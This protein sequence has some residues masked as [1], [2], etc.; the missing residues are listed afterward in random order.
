MVRDCYK[1]GCQNAG[2]QTLQ[3]LFICFLMMK[4][5]EKYG[6]ILQ[7][8]VQNLKNKNNF[9]VFCSDHFADEDFNCAPYSRMPRL[10]SHAMPR[11][12]NESEKWMHTLQII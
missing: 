4:L 8:E 6:A 5:C 2:T 3:L 12:Q 10:H 11:F 1:N 7:N 9:W